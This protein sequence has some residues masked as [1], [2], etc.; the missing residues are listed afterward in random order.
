MTNPGRCRRLTGRPE[1]ERKLALV[2]AR[3]DAACESVD[4]VIAAVE[5]FTDDVDSDRL[6]IDGVVLEELDE[7]DSLVVH[8][9]EHL[10]AH[11][12]VRT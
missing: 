7:Q 4:E 5:Q 2:D 11:P 1:D 9:A 8:I 10:R 3:L 6:S 12:G